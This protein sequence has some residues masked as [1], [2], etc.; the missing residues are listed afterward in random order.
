MLYN[1]RLEEIFGEEDQTSEDMLFD[2]KDPDE[3]DVNETQ[4][5]FID[6]LFSYE[7]FQ[8]RI[9]HKIISISC[10]ILTFEAQLWKEYNFKEMNIGNARSRV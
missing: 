6:I 9:Y 2:E 4:Y 3:S 1:A 8:M 7:I 5:E 10:L